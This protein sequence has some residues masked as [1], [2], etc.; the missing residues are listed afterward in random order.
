MDFTNR[1]GCRVFGDAVMK[2]R[3]PEEIYNELKKA[4][5]QGTR[6]PLEAA[7]VVAQAM[8]DWAIEQGA[9]HYSHWFQPMNSMTAGKLDS[10]LD[11]TADGS[12]VADLSFDALVMSEP[13]ASSFPSGGLR[14]TFEARGYTAWDPTSPAFV[15]DDTLYIPT[16]F[17]TY[18]GLAMDEKTPLL[19]SMQAVSAQALRLMKVMGYDDVTHVEPTVGAEQE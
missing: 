5:E 4:G 11:I 9:T 13:D 16:A 2:E 14:T 3:L 10:F 12:A 17:C 8:K 15:K 19:R 7:R 1:F 6:L 18:T